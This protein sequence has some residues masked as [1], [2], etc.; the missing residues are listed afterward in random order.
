MGVDKLG[1]DEIGLDKMGSRRSGNNLP[2]AL[3]KPCTRTIDIYWL[4]CQATVA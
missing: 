4:N 2:G 3:E 1:V